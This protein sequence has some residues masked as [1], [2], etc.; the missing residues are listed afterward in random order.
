VSYGKRYSGDASQ[1]PFQSTP[2]LDLLNDISLRPLKQYSLELR[3]SGV[4][5]LVTRFKRSPVLPKR[6][7]ALYLVTISTSKIAT[8]R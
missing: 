5:I 7:L 3:S 6:R 4:G 8:A 2:E 1:R